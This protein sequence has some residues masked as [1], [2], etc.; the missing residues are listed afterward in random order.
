MSVLHGLLAVATLKPAVAGLDAQAVTQ[1]LHG[2]LAVA[3]LKLRPALR[4]AQAEASS[5]RPPGCGRIEASTAPS[6]TA[7]HCCGSP[8]PPGCGRIEAYYSSFDATNMIS[9]PR[10][11]G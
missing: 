8:R 11:P 10:P 5:P 9:S 2:L 3:A 4:P 6:S 1:V 7:P